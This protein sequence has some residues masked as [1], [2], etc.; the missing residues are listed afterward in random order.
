[1]VESRLEGAL[2]VSYLVQ[3]SAAEVTSFYA[4][5]LGAAGWKKDE[6]EVWAKGTRQ[7]LVQQTKGEGGKQRVVVLERS[8][9]GAR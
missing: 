2:S 8:A 6:D 1:M 4:D 9:G 5:V 7:I 3:A